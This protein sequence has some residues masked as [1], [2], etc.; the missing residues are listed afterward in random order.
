MGYLIAG[1]SS[2]LTGILIIIPPPPRLGALHFLKE[3]FLWQRCLPHPPGKGHLLIQQLL[4]PL[5][6]PVPL[7]QLTVLAAE[8]ALQLGDPVAEAAALRLHGG[9][10]LGRRPSGGL[11]LRAKSGTESSTERLWGRAGLPP[12]KMAPGFGDVPSLSFDNQ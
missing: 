3:E 8:A 10:L 1:R 2:L 12:L 11:R 4:Q 7:L 6:A 9:P 5:D